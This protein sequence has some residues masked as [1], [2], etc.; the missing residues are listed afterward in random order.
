MI[1]QHSKAVCLDV[2]TSSRFQAPTPRGETAQHGAPAER[3][4]RVKRASPDG[5]RPDIGDCGL[6]MNV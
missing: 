6:R 4:G 5:A 3:D 1:N 2:F